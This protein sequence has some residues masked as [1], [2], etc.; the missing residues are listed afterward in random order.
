LSQSIHV[1]IKKRICCGCGACIV[2]CSTSSISFVYGKRFNYPQIDTNKCNKCG[3]CLKVCPSSFL[4]ND[5][6]QR[7]EIEPPKCD[8]DCYL[9]HSTNENIRRDSASGGFITGTIYH[10][11][12]MRRVDGAVVARC[13]GD[14]PLVAESFIAMDE[15]SLLTAQGSKYTPVSSCTVLSKVLE[16]PGLYVFVGTPCMC[17]ALIK[18]QRYFPDLSSRI[19]L[20]VSFVCAGMASR[21]STSNYIQKDGGVDIEDVRRIC[22]RG[23]GWP[24]RFR[25]YGENRKL[26][27]DR[28]LIGGSLSRVVGQDHYLRCENCLDHWGRYADIVVS[29]PWTKEIIQSETKGR[30]AIMIRTERGRAV[31]ASVIS[32]GGLIANKISIVDMIGYNQHLEINSSHSRHSWI[33]LYQLLFFGRT[34]YLFPIL[35]LF[36]KRRLVGLRTTFRSRF[37]SQYYN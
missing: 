3:K 7:F 21:L 24:G 16:Q 26:L 37:D 12:Q 34:R 33:A 13:Q 4:L 31:L 32:D 30:S 20:I 27:M 15:R 9:A 18:L 19:S 1:I 29:D 14:N 6:Y 23:S 2:A 8:L 11:M 25:V 5:S 10:L 17:E 36:L 35:R 28:P 22:Y